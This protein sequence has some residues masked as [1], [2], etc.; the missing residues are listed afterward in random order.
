MKIGVSR[1]ECT[2]FWHLAEML[3]GENSVDSFNH[4][5]ENNRLNR[6][7]AEGVPPGCMRTVG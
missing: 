1:K 2:S 3:P 5:V 4:I 7:N 6:N